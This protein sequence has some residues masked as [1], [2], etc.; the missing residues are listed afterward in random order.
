M[1][2]LYPIFLKIS[3]QP[4]LVIGGGRVAEQ[5]L[6]TLLECGARITVIAPQVTQWIE[7]LVSMEK[8]QLINRCYQAGDAKGYAI[9]I[10]ATSDAGAQQIIFQEASAQNIPVNIVDIPELSTFYLSC[11]AQRGDLKIAVSTNGKSPTLGKIIRDR[12]EREFGDEYNEML[13][14]LM[15][16]REHI[17]ERLSTVSERKEFFQSL[18]N[19][20]LE[21]LAIKEQGKK[22]I[23]KVY[24][25]G[26]GPGDPELLTLKAL[27]HLQSADVIVYDALVNPALLKLAD[28]NVELIYVGKRAG[29][30]Y[31]RQE[32]INQILIDKA[33][34]G[35]FVVRLKGGDPFIFGRG[36]EEMAAVRGAGIEVEIIPGITAGIGAATA[37]GIPLT[38]RNHSSSVLFLTGHEDCG[39]QRQSID[40]NAVAAAE[41]VVIYMGLKRIAKLMEQMMAKNFDPL[42]PVAVIFAGTLPEEFVVEGTIESIAE[43]VSHYQSGLPAII[44]IGNVVRFLQSGSAKLLSEEVLV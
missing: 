13:Q 10:G 9:I 7:M 44:I 33:R 43:R 1:N 14:E 25:V 12:I 34:E 24:L 38:E 32:E 19:L 21:K 39:K 22:A 11:V 2:N 16:A 36:G 4:A 3:G 8:I 23:G 41:T 40:W 18:V 42:T 28:A 15:A 27:R 31:R 37:L 35:K 30:H 20:Q 17:K 5:K 26:A 29:A 6:K